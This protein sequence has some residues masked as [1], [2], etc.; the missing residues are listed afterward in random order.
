MDE[1]NAI[2]PGENILPAIE[3][4][5]DDPKKPTVLGPGLKRQ[6][7]DRVVAIKPG[8]LVHRKVNSF[9]ISS[10]Q[11]YYIPCERDTIVG[12]VTSKS[13]TFVRVDIGS[14]E[15][16]TLSLFAFP[17]ATKRNKG[18]VDVR[19]FVYFLNLFIIYQN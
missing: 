13:A 1:Y 8:Q 16:A 17:N 10:H 19:Y 2:L 18:I 6:G 3:A 4:N 7:Q 5:R 12:V 11:R 9:W 14:S 15:P